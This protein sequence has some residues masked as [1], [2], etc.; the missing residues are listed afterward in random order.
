MREY[1]D[2]LL[3]G[4]GPPSAGLVIVLLVDSIFEFVSRPFVKL[5]EKINHEKR[6]L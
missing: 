4:K 3:Y 2:A 1:L 6:E 5:A